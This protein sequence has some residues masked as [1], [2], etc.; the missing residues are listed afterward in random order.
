MPYNRKTLPFI[1]HPIAQ[2]AGPL[3]ATS[4]FKLNK[5]VS[6]GLIAGSAL[7]GAELHAATLTIDTSQITVDEPNS[8]S[9]VV[10]VTLR[11][12]FDDNDP[13]WNN[14]TTCTISGT[15]GTSI[16]AEAGATPGIDF[17][18]VGTSFSMTTQPY[19]VGDGA[20]QIDELTEEILF[21]ILDDGD[22][23]ETTEALG[24]TIT[25]YGVTCGEDSTRSISISRSYGS[26]IIND[27]FDIKQ[28]DTPQNQADR[29]IPVRQKSL[30]SQI[31]SIRNLTLHSAN[32]QN[33]SI[34]KEINR[35][36]QSTGLSTENLQVSVKGQNVT[37]ALQLGAGAGDALEDFG[38]WG[39]F[40]SGSIDLG[41]E[42]NGSG[43]E[44]DFEST[45][46][47]VGADY[48]VT[49]NIVLGTAIGQ[50]IVKADQDQLTETDFNRSSLALFGSFYSEDRFYVD[51]IITF[52]FSDYDLNRSITIDETITDSATANTDGDE[53]TGSLGAG[54]NFHKRNTN[55]RIFSFINYVDANVDGYQ[56]TVYGTSSAANV[57]NIDLQSLTSDVGVEFSWNINSDMG[58]FS[59]MMSLAWEH[60]Y[61]DDAV[62]INGRFIGGEDEGGF[63]YHGMDRDDDYLNAQLG[64][65]GVFKN[66]LAASLTYDTYLER[67][68]LSSD[69]ISFNV[70]W[71][72]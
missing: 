55:L 40:I 35:A 9:R 6:S 61:S 37:Q 26:I 19:N 21:E 16:P 63:N 33:R 51:G 32:T 5:L 25:S 50:T 72:F 57:N 20:V 69:H 70:R 66:G 10:A 44:S 34:S 30:S 64:V 48:R 65:N 71:Q 53:I 43:I 17:N 41:K 3:K 28:P 29:A 67:S 52:G 11:A 38:R 23:N 15:L 60:Q 49:D 54:Y 24:F 68:D 31:E 22:E 58:V 13:D 2:L 7:V 59:P 14:L 56:E 36:R 4:V 1:Q 46:L 47:I 8:G 62:D 12:N 42:E 39:F 18:Q 27:P 45:L